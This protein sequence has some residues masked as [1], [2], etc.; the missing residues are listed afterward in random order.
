AVSL[1]KIQVAADTEI[2][3]E[4]ERIRDGTS[5]LLGL[6]SSLS[7]DNLVAMGESFV[8]LNLYAPSGNSFELS[9]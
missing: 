5:S 4:Y 8:G 7:A 1:A 6:S 2:L 3:D 9:I